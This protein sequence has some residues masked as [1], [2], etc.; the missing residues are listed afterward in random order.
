MIVGF[1]CGTCSFPVVFHVLHKT[2]YAPQGSISKL[3]LCGFRSVFHR[4]S[5]LT[6][7]TVDKHQG[8][9]S[10]LVAVGAKQP[11]PTPPHP[12][13]QSEFTSYCCLWLWLL[14]RLLAYYHHYYFSLSQRSQCSSLSIRR[15]GVLLLFVP[16]A[17]TSLLFMGLLGLR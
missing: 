14:L 1:H 17:L 11:Q 4:F 15:T 10:A 7:C 16:T 13:P 2:R 9:C 5:F 12:T 3:T 6:P 8:R